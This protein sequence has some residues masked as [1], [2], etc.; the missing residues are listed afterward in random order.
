MSTTQGLVRNILLV[1][2]DAIFRENLAA[3]LEDQG[4][5]TMQACD[6][7]EAL[8]A[9][10]WETEPDLVLLDMMMTAG[11]FSGNGGRSRP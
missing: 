8:E 4:Y 1:E 6:G 3:I 2:D 5:H 9:H 10:P 11:P 7:K